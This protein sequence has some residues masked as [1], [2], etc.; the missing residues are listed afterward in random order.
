[1]SV[2]ATGNVIPAMLYLAA[3]EGMVPDTVEQIKDAHSRRYH[4]SSYEER[5]K[6]DMEWGRL[7]NDLKILNDTVVPNMRSWLA[8]QVVSSDEL[9]DIEKAVYTHAVTAP[10]R[11]KESDAELLL[12][13]NDLNA[14]AIE[15]SPVYLDRIGALGDGQPRFLGRIAQSGVSVRF[16]DP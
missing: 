16:N 7:G 9:T 11:R 13:L 12:P 1:M 14:A 2:E 15:D 3:A 5:L 4:G 6:A 10:E 8:Q